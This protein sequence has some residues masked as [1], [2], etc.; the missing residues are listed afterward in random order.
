MGDLGLHAGTHNHLLSS[1]MVE[2]IAKTTW[3]EVTMV[4]ILTRTKECT[5]D[6]GF[7]QVTRRGTHLRWCSKS[8][9]EPR[10]VETHVQ[11]SPEHLPLIHPH[12]E[13]K[14]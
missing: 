4:V 2:A 5:K 8:I 9:P 10:E 3:L 1:Y 11:S 7:A 13:L 14:P 6:I 12:V